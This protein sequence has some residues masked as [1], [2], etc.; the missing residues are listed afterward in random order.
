MRL[1]QFVFTVT[2]IPGKD[3]TIADA[4]S[5]A[6][7]AAA[8][9]A[10]TQFSHDVEMFVNTVMSSLPATKQRLTEIAYEQTTDEIC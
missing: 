3:L 2:H 6:P 9:D 10:D 7:T 1:M 5:Q 8:S 4:L